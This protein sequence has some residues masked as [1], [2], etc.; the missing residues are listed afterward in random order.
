MI[1][2]EV[3]ILPDMVAELPMIRLLEPKLILP[4]VSVSVLPILRSLLNATTDE[5]LFMVN[6]DN[7]LVVPG[8]AWL[9][10]RYTKIPL[11]L[12]TTLDDELPIKLFA[13]LPLNEPFIVNVLA[14]IDNCPAVSV[15]APFTVGDA[16]KV[17]TAP[18]L[19]TVRLLRFVDPEGNSTSVV[20]ADALL[21]RLA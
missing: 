15:V 4:A 6:E 8:V 16:P 19:F 11:P 5:D 17:I 2:F 7:S 21:P 13:A 14:A 3:D 20:T 10:N 9:K 1:I 18:V 12:I